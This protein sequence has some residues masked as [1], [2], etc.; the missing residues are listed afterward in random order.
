MP[1]LSDAEAASQHHV[2]DVGKILLQ[3]QSD[4]R[5]IRERLAAAAA[6]GGGG[7]APSGLKGSASAVDFA[8][9]ESLQQVVEK[10]EAELR[11]KAEAVLNSVTQ[12]TVS[13]LPMLG[14]YNFSNTQPLETTA[15]PPTHAKLLRRKPAPAP[16]PAPI[17]QSVSAGDPRRG[18]RP[19][20]V[21]RPAAAAVAAER[22]RNAL[23]NPTSAATRQLMQDR[24][25]VAPPQAHA[26]LRP[27]G[28]VP[29][30]K[31]KRERVSR[32][33]G[34]PPPSVRNDPQAV[35]PIGPKDVAAGLYSLVTRGLIPPAVDL[36]PAMER[37]PAP[38]LQAPAR[39]HDFGSQFG[40][41]NSAAYTA[42]F[43]FNVSNTKLDLLSDVGVTLAE[44]R[45]R[46]REA[47]AA[48]EA[49]LP[50]SPVSPPADDALVGGDL[51][52]PDGGADHA[53][54]TS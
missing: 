16:I 43:G 37:K 48:A 30:G 23:R 7:G 28:R 5:G 11:L 47:E 14:A 27:I 19:D 8:A 44:Q 20:A 42:P 12:G 32:A 17:R 29:P 6:S 21:A 15:P 25:G 38:L 31:L 34:V 4:L 53:S 36:T 18:G 40:A 39:V 46:Q 2:K 26:P 1:S 13:T 54:S 49:A 33:L 24:F 35:P 45:Q 9:G 10:V 22:E 3:A 41:H 50:T 51:A 52:P